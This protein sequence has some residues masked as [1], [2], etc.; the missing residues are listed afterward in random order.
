MNEDI[1]VPVGVYFQGCYNPYYEAGIM[2]CK[3]VCYEYNSLRPSEHERRAEILGDLL[4]GA[5]RNP[6]FEPPFFCD[7]GGHIFVGDDFYANR[8]LV[9]NDGAEV[10][11]GNNFSSVRTAVSPRRNT[12]SIPRCARRASSLQ[13]PLRWATMY[14]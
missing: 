5:G 6:I 14:G 11:F 4:G 8:N 12:P 2:K 13:S 1:F 10:R 7:Y 9:V 3:E